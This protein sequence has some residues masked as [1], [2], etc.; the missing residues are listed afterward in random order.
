MSLVHKSAIV[1]VGTELT[2]GTIQD[3]HGKYLASLLT[4]LGFS[5]EYIVIV[6]DGPAITAELVR[7]AGSV[8]LALVAGG[9][10]PTSD[11]ITRESV[12]RIA[13]APL[14]FHDDLWDE[15]KLKLKR[16]SHHQS[17]PVA[18]SNRKQAEIPAGFTPI[19]NTCGT[20]PGFWGE[21]RGTTLVVMPGPPRELQTMSELFLSPFL[22]ERFKHGVKNLLVGTTFL[23]AESQL[24]DALGKTLNNGLR[25]RTRAEGHRI[26][27]SLYTDDNEANAKNEEL[28][29]RNLF[30][31]FGR[32]CIARDETTAAA[33]L[34]ASLEK[35]RLRLVTAESC[36]GG[37]IAKMVTD[38]P[39]SSQIYWGGFNTYANEAKKRILGVEGIE[40]YGAVSRETVQQMAAGALAVSSADVAIAISGIAGPDG[41]TE[42]KPVGTVWIA[43]HIRNG[44]SHA[45]N[46]NMHGDRNRIRLRSAVAALRIADGLIAGL[47]VDNEPIWTYI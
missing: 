39:G 41:G 13:E 33:L 8:D 9:I 19:E 46:I 30:G 20:A 21:I 45:W 44:V 32:L 40:Q 15:I 47:S 34:A 29:W 17:Q 10:G 5:V 38:L 2:A 31:R 4:A 37:L 16:I 6:P 11:D 14:H 27:F 28:A 18:E 43:V 26:V 42:E 24:E 12:A 23:I 1:L 3:I 22:K 35:K 7:C 25:W 36:T